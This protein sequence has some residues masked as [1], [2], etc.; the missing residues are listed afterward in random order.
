MIRAVSFVVLTLLPSI[1]WSDGDTTQRRAIETLTKFGAQIAFD[2]KAP[3]RPVVGI[4]LRPGHFDPVYHKL[5]DGSAA[6][7]AIAA[8]DKVERLDLANAEFGDDD[9]LALAGLRHVKSIHV[10]RS[11][12]T[13]RGIKAL[14]GWR[15]LEILSLNGLAISSAGLRHFAMLPNI[16]ILDLCYTKIDDEGMKI[17]A[18]MTRLQSL[19]LNSTAVSDVGLAE[20]AGLTTLESLSLAGTSTSGAG[21][22]KLDGNAKL[23]SLELGSKVGDA[24]LTHIL[25]FKKLRS[26]TL[27][28]GVTD[29]GM[30]VVAQ[31]RELRDLDL[32]RLLITSKG[33]GLLA[34][35]LANL[36]SIGLSS[37]DLRDPAIFR[38]LKRLPT[39]SY[40]NACFATVSDASMLE[41]G[42]VKTL[43]TIHLDNGEGLTRDNV[44][45]LREALP[46]CRVLCASNGL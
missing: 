5:A 2:D 26:L 39:L 30:K 24:G 23:E 15:S 13:D 21:L 27:G 42:N 40:I 38:E 37:A 46:K 18:K 41:L 1:A 34:D 17:V 28:D 16:R 19:H 44:T 29:E 43:E 33:Y 7:L 32:G 8:F 36:E 3:G 20:L 45:R 10:S 14:E 4:E 12:L 25:P 9:F 6:I 22:A 11:K 31:L 35:R